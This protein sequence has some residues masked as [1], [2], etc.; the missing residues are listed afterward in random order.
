MWTGRWR[1]VWSHVLVRG[2][3]RVKLAFGRV[4]DSCTFAVAAHSPP[5]GG[6]HMMAASLLVVLLLGLASNPE[7]A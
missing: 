5:K 3:I 2:V 6:V 1:F 7:A 4:I